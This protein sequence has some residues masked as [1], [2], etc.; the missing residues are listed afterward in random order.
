[1]GVVNFSVFTL[2]CSCTLRFVLTSQDSTVLIVWLVQLML[3]VAY[4]IHYIVYASQYNFCCLESN[5]I[6]NL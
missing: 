2:L 5:D 3:A 4:S 6:A 1:M